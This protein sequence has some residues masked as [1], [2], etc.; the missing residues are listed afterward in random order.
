VSSTTE[1]LSVS[2]P[3]DLVRYAD[4]YRKSHLMSSRSEVLAEA[5]RALRER[6]LA[7]GY[8]ELAE[9]HARSVDPML[10]AGV[11]DG[12]EPSIGENW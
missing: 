7:Q 3:Q 11:A 12:L 9:E 8:R 4:K 10:D 1:K 5:V 2:L 6:E